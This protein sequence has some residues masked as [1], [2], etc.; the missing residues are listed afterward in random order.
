MNN[1]EKQPRPVIL[2]N[3]FLAPKFANLPI[4]WMLE[5][6][7]FQAHLIDLPLLNLT[8]MK[9][10]ARCIAVGVDTVLSQEN[11]S[12]C[13]MIGVSLGGITGLY[14]LKKL[15]GHTK[16]K[17]FIAFGTPFKGTWK[18]LLLAPVI[19]MFSK[20]LW[21]TLPGNTILS[22]LISSP[23][24][25]TDVYSI[26]AANDLIAPMESACLDW[27]KNIEVKSLPAPISHQG[28]IT[29]KQAMSHIVQI[30]KEN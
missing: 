8:D 25:G 14:Y 24:E 10:I 9:E 11:I 21:Q 15:E 16:V 3:G 7:G 20:S 5:S 22:D 23:V 6:H 26:Y 17:N 4:K 18:A 29:S 27:T 2:I 30:L 1:Q 12:H 13:D 19:G 28:L